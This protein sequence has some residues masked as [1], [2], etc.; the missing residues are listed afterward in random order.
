[1]DY[2]AM[3][4][5]IRQL[6]LQK[7]LTQA[8]LAEEAEISTA[9]VGHIERGTRVMSLETFARLCQTLGAD[10]EWLLGISESGNELQPREELLKLL[11]RSAQLVQRI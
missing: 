10:A 4:R 6:R 9:F 3:G 11:E 7:E 2:A 1:M 5:R 8:A